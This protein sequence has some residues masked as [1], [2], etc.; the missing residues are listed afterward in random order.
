MSLSAEE[1][2]R[3][4]HVLDELGIPLIEAGFPA[5]NP[6][7]A[8]LFELLAR[9][10]FARR[11]RRLRDDAPARRRGG[12]RS[13]AARCSP[14]RS[15]R[16]ARWSARP[17]RCTSRRSCASTR[18]EN[19]RDDRRLGRLP[20]GRRASASSTTPS[21]SSTATATTPPTRCVPARRRRGG[22][23]ERRRCATPTARRCRTRSP[24]RPRAV[25]EALAA[26][27]GS[28]S[29][30][31]T[32]PSA[33]SPT[34]SPPSRPG[35]THGAG[36]DERLRRALRQRQ[37]R[38]D[39]PQ[40]AAEDGL[41]TACRRALAALTEAAHFVDELLNCTPDP[42]QPY[43]GKNAFAHKGGMHV[44]GV[45]ADPATFE[46]IDPAAVGNARELLISELSGKGTVLE[47]AQ[48][49]RRARRRRPPRASSSASR[50]SST[51]ATSSRP[52]TA[53][54]T[55]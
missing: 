21:T 10:R 41:P 46:H 1:K 23:R 13:G 12:G 14:T 19:L 4:A 11:R 18:D 31:T 24:P 36:H 47:R 54:S 3:V 32:T 20:R 45:N 8:E 7:E 22:R 48:R 52:P 37:P 53:R 16:S 29:T 39:H 34:R 5:S 42:N 15:R 40:P 27:S 30:A 6:K 2:L 28:A 50:R 49:R 51:A 35:A 55:C 38:L 25:R 44:A 33:A 17:G 26:A 43:V 9:E